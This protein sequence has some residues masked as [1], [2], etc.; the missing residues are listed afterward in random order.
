MYNPPHFAVEDRA[1][2]YA[3][4]RACRLANLVTAG[5]SGLVATPLPMILDEA[6]A[7]N[8]VLYGHIA[9]A[10]PHW[11]EAP[12]Q[13]ALAIFSGPDAYISPNW[14]A[15]KARDGKVVPTWNYIAIHVYG[16]VEFFHEPERLLDVVARL[17]A[18]HEAG[19]PRP[20]SVADAPPE[21]I[22]SQLRGIVG[23]RIPITRIEAKRKMNQNRSAEDRAGVVRALS[24]SASE[25][26]RSVAKL[27]PE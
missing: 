25:T 4:V 12:Q 27:I 19:Q 5:A 1:E 7:E 26:D 8:G 11:K 2:I 6:G 3:M 18:M 17:T 10:N 9:K 20:W 13:D 22:Q 16:P 21:F 15:S 24:A 23:I 14:Y